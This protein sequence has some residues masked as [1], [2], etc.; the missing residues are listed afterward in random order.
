MAEQAAQPKK[1][2]RKKL[3]EGATATKAKRGPKNIEN[4][5]FEQLMELSNRITEVMKT[6]KDE[7]IK[8]LKDKLARLENM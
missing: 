7:Q 5:S 4:M 1:R 2:G 8:A 3:G 6:K